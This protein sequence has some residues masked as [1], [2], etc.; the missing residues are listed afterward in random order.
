M[1]GKT[2]SLVKKML[3]GV[4]LCMCVLG[5]PVMAAAKAGPVILVTGFD[6]FG[7]AASNPTE[8]AVKS[9]PDK[10]GKARIVKVVLPT[11][12]TRSQAKLHK[13]MREYK[14]DAVICLGLYD[15]SHEINVERVAIN[16]QDARI[17]DNDG[18]RPIDKPVVEG[19]PVGYWSTLPIKS[20]VQDLRNEGYPAI[21]SNSAGT[22]VCNSTMYSLC[23]YIAT[24]SPN[25]LGGFVHVPEVGAKF[26]QGTASFS[27][28]SI[29]KCVLSVVR[30][31]E[32]RLDA[33]K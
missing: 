29:N 24:E 30:T 13:A 33:K 11:V 21:V 5:A 19:G 14:P 18:Q 16:V 2:S 23:H 4:G 9:L 27:Q 8:T 15:G 7:S 25:I 3:L 22:F 20:I 26:P 28:G 12:F 31:V 32:R 17:P 6:P 10:V 1:I